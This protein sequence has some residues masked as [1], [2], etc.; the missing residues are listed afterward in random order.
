[1][2]MLYGM[3]YAQFWYGDPWMARAY[4]EAYLLKR[5]AKNEELWLEGIYVANAFQTVLGNAFSKKK[6]KYLEKPLDIFPKTQ[7]EKDQEIREERQRLIDWL[8]Q[9]KKSAVD[10]Q[11]VDKH[12][13]LGNT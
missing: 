5:K 11:G 12:G 4:S 13:E 2:Y 7:A 1:M 3:T 8:S 9:L 10:K 6:L